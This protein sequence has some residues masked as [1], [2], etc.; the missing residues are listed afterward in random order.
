HLDTS[1]GHLRTVISEIRRV[2][3]SHP[4]IE[5]DTIRVRL[6]ELTSTSINVELV[7]YVLTRDFDEFTEVREDLL[8]QIMK[9]VEDSGT[10][11]ASPSQTLY[12]SGDPAAQPGRRLSA[13]EA[14]ADGAS[15]VRGSADRSPSQSGTRNQKLDAEQ[16][17]KNG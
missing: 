2:L 9:F 3:S 1:A 16:H 4:K 12:L 6:T 10:S 5:P 8:L 14:T 7:C 11:L 15:S 13:F 17:S